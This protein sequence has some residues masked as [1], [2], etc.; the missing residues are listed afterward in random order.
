MKEKTHILL[1]KY[2]I[3]DLPPKK[4]GDIIITIKLKV[5]EGGILS[6][7][8]Y[9]NEKGVAPISRSIKTKEALNDEEKKEVFERIKAMNE[10]KDL[11]DQ[12]NTF[13]NKFCKAIS[14]AEAKGKDVES[15]K[16]YY[17]TI[18]L[19]MPDN[20]GLTE[21]IEQIDKKI[22]EINKL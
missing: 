20:K 4:K 5:D 6:L 7:E 14:E 3:S 16:S 9:C 1:G 15:Y 17:D 11:I 8:A 10:R 19:S 21:V 13:L 2:R 18:K 22:K 12:Y